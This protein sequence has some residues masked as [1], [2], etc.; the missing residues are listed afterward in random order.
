M[1][2]SDPRFANIFV[3]ELKHK[4]FGQSVVKTYSLETL[5][6]RI[7]NW[8]GVSTSFAV[9]QDRF[10]VFIRDSEYANTVLSV[11]I[12]LA[13]FFRSRSLPFNLAGRISFSYPI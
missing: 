12:C 1:C 11:P 4:L 7:F 8:N 9:F 13:E 3:A 6:T 10:Q 5:Q 2:L